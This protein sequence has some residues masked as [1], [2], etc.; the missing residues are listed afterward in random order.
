MVT[1]TLILLILVGVELAIV[2]NFIYQKARVDQV[3]KKRTSELDYLKFLTTQI[4]GEEQS[5]EGAFKKYLDYLHE[6][7]GWRYHS[8]FRLDEE[9]QVLVIRFTGNLP[10]WY[11]KDLSTK[12]LVKVG[13]ASV[14]RAVANKQPVTI[15]VASTDPRFQNV[16]SLTKATGYNSVSCYPLNGKIKTHGGFCAYSEHENIFSLHDTQFL[17]T[18]ANLFAAILDS[19]LFQNYLSKKSFVA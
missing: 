3:L 15:N 13:D 7:V 12:V 16:S 5:I 11:M 19:K 6:L 9:R 1:I 17:L 8:I 14:G 4:M 10:D 18:C 2:L